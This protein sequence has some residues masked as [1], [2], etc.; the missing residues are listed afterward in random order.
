MVAIAEVAEIAEVDE[1]ELDP[2][3]TL[4][5]YAWDAVQDGVGYDEAA[6][7]AVD[8]CVRRGWCEAVAPTLIHLAIMARVRDRS[9][10]QMRSYTGMARSNGFGRADTPAIALAAP[11]ALDTTQ[12]EV[13]PAKDEHY[14]DVA[15]TVNGAAKALRDMTRDEVDDACYEYLKQG[16][17]KLQQAAFLFNVRQKMGKAAVVSDAL[18]VADVDKLAH[19]YLSTDDL[20]TLWMSVSKANSVY[21]SKA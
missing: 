8:M 17:G 2:T 20:A 1:T 11:A 15:Y 16:R 3:D 14:W 7:R 19:E 6:R 10:N 12:P 21:R 4:I 9:H 5:D 13:R 18:T